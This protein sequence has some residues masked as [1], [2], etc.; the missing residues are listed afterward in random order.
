MLDKVR[1]ENLCVCGGDK[2]VFYI[3]EIFD[4]LIYMNV[5]VKEFFCWRLL[6]IFILYNVD[7]DFFIIFEYII[8]KG[9]MVMFLVYLVFYD[10]VVYFDLEIFDLDWWIIGDVELKMRNW[11]V[12]GFGGYDCLVCKYV[13][14][15]MVLMI[16]KVVMGWKWVYYFMLLLEKI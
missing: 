11:F 16:G 14:L 5:V 10:L 15:F 12:F 7:K 4:K 6:V 8:F 3:F 2:D 1:E 9:L 13:L